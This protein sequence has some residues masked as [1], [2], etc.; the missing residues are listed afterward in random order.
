MGKNK[1]FV[2]IDSDERVKWLKGEKRPINNV[3]DRAKM[4]ENLK[5]IDSVVIFNSNDEMR[6]FI[7]KFEIDYMVV[8]DQYKDKIVIG[9]EC[10]K[11][12]VIY[13]PTD[14]RSTTNIIEK[15]KDLFYTF[16]I[17]NEFTYENK[18]IKIASHIYDIMT[19]MIMFGKHFPSP[20]FYELEVLEYIKSRFSG[21]TA[22]DI[23]ANIGNHSIY[24]S[25][26]IF[27]KTFAFEPNPKNMSLLVENKKI[28]NITDD[29]LLIY[30]T[31]L[32]D[33]HY[34]YKNEENE[35]N[36][37]GNKIIEGEG[38]LTTT[39]I[40]DYEFPKIDFIKIDVEGHEL[41]VLKGAINLI[42]RDFPEIIIECYPNSDS[43][44][45]I[46]NPYMEELGY[47]SIKTFGKY[48]LAYYIHK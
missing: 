1:L 24:F 20:Q 19:N 35:K 9:A 23:G 33:G 4:L 7:K 28:N 39:T 3:H 6:Y 29:K 27:D 8:G 47:Q 41:K 31:A 11:L 30:H 37:G 25:K 13:Y 14:E 36:M 34:K 21:G 40:D 48:V 45:K 15:I 46:I 2:G 38:D 17:T 44:F 32:S 16:H 43:D 5:M 12:G 18:D 42:K 22:F 10:A 26:F